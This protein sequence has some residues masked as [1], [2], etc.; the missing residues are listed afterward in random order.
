V[1][2]PYLAVPKERDPKFIPPELWVL[3]LKASGRQRKLQ[4]DLP[5]RNYEFE[6]LVLSR[7][8]V[9]K[10]RKPSAFELLTHPGGGKSL[11]WL[12]DQWSFLQ[13]EGEYAQVRSNGQ[14]GWVFVPEL[15]KSRPEVID[16]VSGLIRTY[17]ADWEGA[18]DAFSRAAS[19]TSAPTSIKLD[20]L[21]FIVRAKTEL[22]LSASADIAAIRN[23]APPSRRAVQY[24]A[25]HLLARCFAPPSRCSKEEQKE[26]TAL[27][28]RTRALF[29]DGDEWFTQA[30][31]IARAGP[32]HQ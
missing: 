11:G 12:A 25:M 4:V 24:I 5:K 28:E 17:A 26:L 22:G 18:A 2:A 21:L 13:R 3:N 9:E 23:L 16:F 10:Y 15:A 19:N 27:L 1:V 8:F 31:E 30:Y 6:P 20:S 14:E 7:S 32:M 29:L